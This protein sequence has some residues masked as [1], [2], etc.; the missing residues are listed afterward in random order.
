MLIAAHIAMKAMEFGATS[1]RLTAGK[2][3]GTRKGL[4]RHDP[5]FGDTLTR[6]RLGSTRDRD[7]LAGWEFL[8]ATSPSRWLQ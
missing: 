6:F 1:R 7:C 8:A 3:E 2:D 5:A 4:L